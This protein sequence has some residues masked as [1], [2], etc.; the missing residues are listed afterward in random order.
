MQAGRDHGMKKMEDRV[1]QQSSQQEGAQCEDARLDEKLHGQLCSAAAQYFSD[2]DFFGSADRQ[3]GREIDK[4][5][6]SEQ[7]DKD[8]DTSQD[9]LRL[10]MAFGASVPDLLV[11]MHI[12]QR[13]KGE[14]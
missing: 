1:Y 2:A 12:R 13:L 8:S 5:D 3:G 10:R 14:R 6:H 11:E 9:I 4:I 7:Q